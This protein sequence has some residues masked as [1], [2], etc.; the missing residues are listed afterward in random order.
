[1]RYYR[2]EY[3]IQVLPNTNLMQ[4][5]TRMCYFTGFVWNLFR[6]GLC[7]KKG[8]TYFVFIALILTTLCV[9][10]WV[11]ILMATVFFSS[12]TEKN[13]EAHLMGMYK[14]YGDIFS[15]K[16]LRVNRL[17]SCLK[18]CGVKGPHGEEVLYLRGADNFAV[19]DMTIIPSCC[20]RNSKDCT[21]SIAYQKGCVS[22]I[23]S[24]T[25]NDH[26]LYV[27]FG[28]LNGILQIITSRVVLYGFVV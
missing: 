24:E 12:M 20:P 4:L 3:R 7:K 17:Q 16:S 9:M 8:A 2:P 13:I 27:R 19:W 25:V 11:D 23:L 1:M 14:V 26:L 22:A 21:S 18:C 15:Y 10:H 28:I 5:W 6:T